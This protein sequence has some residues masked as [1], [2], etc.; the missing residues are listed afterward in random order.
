MVAFGWVLT[1][2]ADEVLSSYDNHELKRLPSSFFFVVFR[3]QAKKEKSGKQRGFP[4]LSGGGR[5]TL[6]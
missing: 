6:T 4:K 2:D 5:Y 3:G 1:V